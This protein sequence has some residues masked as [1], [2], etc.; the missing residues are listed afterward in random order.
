VHGELRET[1]SHNP[2]QYKLIASPK[3]THKRKQST[4]AIATDID[5]C[6]PLIWLDAGIT[7]LKPL[8]RK[9]HLRMVFF[10]SDGI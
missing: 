9:I 10:L 4:V 1:A 7:C 5:T 2:S 6:S 8:R 3:H